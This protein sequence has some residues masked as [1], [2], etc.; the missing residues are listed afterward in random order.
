MSSYVPPHKRNASNNLNKNKNKN[1]NNNS[2]SMKND[3]PSL[4][5]SNNVVNNEKKN[6]YSA[7][8]K[9]NQKTK[10]SKKKSNNFGDNLPPGWISLK[11]FNKNKKIREAQ[12]LALKEEEKKIQ[13]E[14][15]NSY[16]AEEIHYYIN[17]LL[18]PLVNKWEQEKWEEYQRN[19]YVEFDE[20]IVNNES[21]YE[22]ME[23]S[24]DSESEYE[25][26]SDGEPF[27]DYD[28][29][30]NKKFLTI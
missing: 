27:N 24:S 23:E 16:S 29:L 28:L 25:V 20:V 12:E 21:D 26:D 19:G 8:F 4:G 13:E 18:E 9:K 11:E 15:E 14:I 5:S 6:D 10:K 30:D 2:I 22:P 3:F 17:D 7:L 1:K